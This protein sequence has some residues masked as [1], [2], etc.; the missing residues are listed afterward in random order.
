MIAIQSNAAEFGRQL[1]ALLVEVDERI[2]RGYWNWSM[3]IFADLVESTPQWSGD[4]ASNWFYTLNSPSAEYMPLV[5]KTAG[6]TWDK[7]GHG[8]F[9]P[10]QRGAPMAVMVSVDRA[11]EGPRPTYRDVVYFSNNTP[12]S[13]DTNLTLV[14]SDKA[15]DWRKV[16]PVNLVENQVALSEFMSFK[17]RNL[18]YDASDFIPA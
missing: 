17:W 15:M 2:N 16:R 18:P 5:G 13:F 1:E 3:R 12:L 7:P 6:A 8:A 10:F 11:M 4:L 9:E 14:A